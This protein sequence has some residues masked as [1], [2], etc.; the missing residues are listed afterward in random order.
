MAPGYYTEPYCGGLLGHSGKGAGPRCGK[1]TERHQ[2][3]FVW[4]SWHKPGSDVYCSSR[5]NEECMIYDLYWT[6]KSI[7]HW[8]ESKTYDWVWIQ[9]IPFDL[10]KGEFVWSEAKTIKYKKLRATRWFQKVKYM[11]KNKNKQHGE[12]E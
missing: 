12:S 2:K 5:W 1:S 7:G 6:P 9:E 11:K 3:V 10:A 8:W 4:P